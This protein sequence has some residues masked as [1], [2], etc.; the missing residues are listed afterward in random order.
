MSRR[1][2][3][4]VAFQML[5]QMSEGANEWE[6]AQLTLTEAE[7]AAGEADYASQLSFGAWEHRFEIAEYI[8]KFITGWQLERL[9]SVDRELLHLAIYELKYGGEPQAV[10]INEAVEL[11]K[12]Y[13][14]DESPAFVNAVLDNF[15]AK[16]LKENLP[17]Y[18]P[19]EAAIEQARAAE[20]ARMER[21]VP[22]PEPEEEPKVAPSMP[23][24]E[25]MEKRGFRKIAKA[26]QTEQD[27]IL[28]EPDEEEDEF[29][30]PIFRRD[31]ER[32]FCERKPFEKRDGERKFGE[33]KPFEKR[34]GERKFGDK[35]FGDKKFGDKKP[36]KKDFNKK[37]F[38]KKDFKKDSYKKDSFKKDFKKDR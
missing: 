20:Q 2:A 5:F 6:M 29:G 35:K 12:L 3:R 8:R 27:V 36:F 34:D 13:G 30:R 19:D 10:V 28:P 7:L 9:F 16:V 31:G 18:Q 14:R 21:L 37:D 26:E 32:K 4:E 38:N 25:K 24:T 17:E 11:A 33:R 23:I 22:E 15:C 1:K